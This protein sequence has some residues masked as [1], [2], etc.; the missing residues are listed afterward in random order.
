ME[1]REKKEADRIFIIEGGK[2]KEKRIEQ[3][4]ERAY[5]VRV[6]YRISCTKSFEKKGKKERSRR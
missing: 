3:N 1:V 4:Y 5:T 6:L 2:R